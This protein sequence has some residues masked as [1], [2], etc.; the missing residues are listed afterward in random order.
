MREVNMAVCKQQS[1]PH[2]KKQCMTLTSKRHEDCFC[3]A[4][5]IDS[6]ILYPDVTYGIVTT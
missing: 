5:E 1:F 4:L 6:H 3:I 2:K